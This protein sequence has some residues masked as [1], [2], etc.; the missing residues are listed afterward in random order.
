MSLA[1]RTAIVTGAAQGIGAAHVRALVGAG[2]DVLV[3]DVLDEPGQRLC[4]ELGAQ[5]AYQP[6]DVTTPD[7][8][9]AAVARAR[10][11]WGR[12]V[13]ILV[14][15]AGIADPVPFEELTLPRW[16][17]T[18]DIHLTGSFLGIAAVVADMREAGGGQIVN[19]ASMT[20]SRASNAM[21]HYIASKHAVIGLTKA[22][23]MDLGEHGIRVNAVQP[24]F[25]DTQMMGGAPEEL[26]AGSLPIPRYGRPEEVADLM[27]YLVERATYTTGAVYAVDGGVTVGE[28]RPD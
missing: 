13:T 1:A 24:G 14:N 9:Q 20:A 27:L 28:R 22:A 15:N 10:E 26:V 11:V 12:P 8:W 2:A 17:R 3:T 19:T 6:L 16:Q 7:A 25:V 5:T 4:E 18:L 23:A 21:A